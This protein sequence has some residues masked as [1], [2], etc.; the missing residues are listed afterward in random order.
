MLCEIDLTQGLFTLP[1]TCRSGTGNTNLWSKQM[2]KA[3][4]SGEWGG[5]GLTGH[6]PRELWGDGNV[7]IGM[8]AGCTDVFLCRSGTAQ[9]CAF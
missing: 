6:W 2:E 9:I 4:A 8:G 1:C 5:Q 7:L 3:V